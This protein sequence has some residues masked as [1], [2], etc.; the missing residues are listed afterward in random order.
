V[1]VVIVVIVVISDLCTVKVLSE[2]VVRMNALNAEALK[3]R[4]IEFGYSFC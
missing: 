2:S 1:I 3:C 4:S